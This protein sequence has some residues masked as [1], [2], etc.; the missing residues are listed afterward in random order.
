MYELTVHEAFAAAHRLPN[1]GGRCERLH[2]HNW[3]VEVRVAAD[4]L[5]ESGMVMDFHDVK[6]ALQGVLE[7]LD[8]RFLND[9][10]AFQHNLPTA[11][12]LAR[13]ICSGLAGRL[14]SPRVRLTRVRVWESEGTAASFSPPPSPAS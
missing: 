3:K 1:T 9:L 11:E 5:D 10:P 14:P 7:E 2:G 6:A 13:Y 4:Q 12:N 8:H